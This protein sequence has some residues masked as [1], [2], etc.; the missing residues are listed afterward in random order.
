M[1]LSL[2]FCVFLFTLLYAAAFLRIQTG[3]C[4]ARRGGGRCEWVGALAALPFKISPYFFVKS[5]QSPELAGRGN[6]FERICIDTQLRLLQ[7]V[8]YMPSGKVNAAVLDI[9]QTVVLALSIF[10]V[11]YFFL[12]RPHQVR[13]ESMYPALYD[14]EYL[15]T[16]KVTY[17]IG[18]P[19]RGDIIVFRA[20]VQPAE[21]FIKRIIGLPGERIMI[22]EGKVYI[23]DTAIKEDY[24][25]DGLET[26]AGTM[27]EGKE[28]AVPEDEY[29][30][31]GDNRPNSTDSRRLGTIKH[32][33]IVGRAWV[34]YWPPSRAGVITHSEH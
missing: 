20:P 21:D 18:H 16:D 3:L 2:N 28:I 1:F 15:L 27:G 8:V 6:R 31:M 17:R 13:G 25:P 33:K 7:N 14:M 32:K 11:V 4:S 12:V 23:N 26:S 5:P 19:K 9:L 22:K 24:L 10:L 30:V 34:L 29:F